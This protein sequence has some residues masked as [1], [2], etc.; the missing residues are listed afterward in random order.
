MLKILIIKIKKKKKK[1]QFGKLMGEIKLDYD[2]VIT[3]LM[4][5]IT[6]FIVD[7]LVRWDDKFD[8]RTGE[9][10]YEIL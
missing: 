8:Y 2:V 6:F 5:I 9:E 3:F 4:S 7:L 1:R 10:I